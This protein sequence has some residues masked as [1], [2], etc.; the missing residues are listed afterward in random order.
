MKPHIDESEFGYITVEGEKILHDI[1]IATDGN[2]KT[3][4]K[5]L[6]KAVFG[7]SHIISL[8]EA[9]EVYEMEA[10]ELIIGAGQYDSV[11]LSE[12]AIDFFDEK[13][14]KIK[15]FPTP[16]AILYWNRYEGH[17]IGLFHVT[18]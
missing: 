5:K 14:C 12:E 1:Y 17:A 11:K 3:R 9:K 15:L 16:E 8:G 6:S 13:Q 18:C 4:N 10:N 7:T 2:V